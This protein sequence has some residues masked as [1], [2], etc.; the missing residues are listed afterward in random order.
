[1]HAKQQKLVGLV[2]KEGRSVEEATALEDALYRLVASTE[3]HKQ[4]MGETYKVMAMTRKKVA[5]P[6]PFDLDI[7][8]L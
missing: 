8:K 3:H 7:S 4:G 5:A 2:Q 6:F 1:V